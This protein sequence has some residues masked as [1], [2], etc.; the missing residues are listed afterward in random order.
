ME[1]ELCLLHYASVLPA[2]NRSVLFTVA[3][4]P[5]SSKRPDA[6]RNNKYPFKEISCTLLW[7]INFDR[8]LRLEALLSNFKGAKNWVQLYTSR[9][10]SLLLPSHPLS[11]HWYSAV[12]SLEINKH[13]T[14]LLW[15]IHSEFVQDFSCVSLKSSKECT[16]TI[17]YNKAKLAI[18]RKQRC[19]SLEQRSVFTMRNWFAL[20]PGSKWLPGTTYLST[21]Q[22]N[23]Q[24]LRFFTSQSDKGWQV[25][26]L[27]LLQVT[28]QMMKDIERN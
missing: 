20:D 14:M 7:F 22:F 24:F 9:L 17:Y 13:I 5:K 27:G 21:L 15:K 6:S 3:W 18:I 25:Q 28:P 11:T 16:T 2:R 26:K 1:L 23:T 19:K 4:D 12:S 8:R 10:S